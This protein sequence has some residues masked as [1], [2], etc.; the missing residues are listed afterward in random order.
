MRVED[1]AFWLAMEDITRTNTRIGATD[2]KAETNNWPSRAIE[3]A[4]SGAKRPSKIPATK[5]ITI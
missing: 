3:C 4:A 2:F 5:P 1:W